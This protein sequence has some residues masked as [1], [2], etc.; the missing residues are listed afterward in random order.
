M[1]DKPRPWKSVLRLECMQISPTEETANATENTFTNVGNC[2][3]HST[4]SFTRKVAHDSTTLETVLATA[5]TV[6]LTT[7]DTIFTAPLTKF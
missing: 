2:A 3:A 1:H 6:E 4:N 5:L 7:L